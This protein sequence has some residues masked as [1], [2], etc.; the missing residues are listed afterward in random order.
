M[1]KRHRKRSQYLHEKTDPMVQCATVSGNLGN[2]NPRVTHAAHTQISSC[3]LVARR[4][5]SK[6]V[7]NTINTHTQNSLHAETHTIVTRRGVSGSLAAF[8]ACHIRK[9][10]RIHGAR[11]YVAAAKRKQQPRQR[12]RR[13][14]SGRV[15]ERPTTLLLLAVAA[16]GRRG[17]VGRLHALAPNGSRFN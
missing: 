2:L 5:L 8:K 12:R 16:A 6:L 11:Q 7:K 3:A 14:G 1:T 17:G 4:A 13:P 10:L 9:K 15:G